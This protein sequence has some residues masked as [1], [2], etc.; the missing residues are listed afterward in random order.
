MQEPIKLLILT[1]TLGRGGA[2]KQILN[3]GYYLDPGRFRVKIVSMTALGIMGKKGLAAGLDI[4]GI[5]LKNKKKL[6]PRF[7][8]IIRRVRSWKPDILLTF[9]VHATLLG[10]LLRILGM[11]RRHIS[12]V[13]STRMGNRLNEILFRLTNAFDDVTTV[14]STN[15]AQHLIVNGTLQVG[16]I[17]VIPNGIDVVDYNNVC[18]Y[19][20]EHDAFTWIIVARIVK[21]KDYDTLLAA[22]SLLRRSGRRFVLRSVGDGVWAVRIRKRAREM[23]LEGCIE[24]LGT[25]SDI[26]ELLT[27][28]DAFVL[29]SA[30]EG[31]PNVVMEAAAASLPVVCT[32]VG[33]GSEL[34]VEG[35][36]GFLVPPGNPEALAEAMERMMRLPDDKRKAMGRYGRQHIE[37]NYSVRTVLEMWYR[38][39]VEVGRAA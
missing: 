19:R 7:L 6:V 32:D 17:V 3:L 33:G 18:E 14:N 39:L 1:S 35:R 26:P 23:S 15:T 16:R 22:V 13:R 31:M 5:D 37:R 30:W 4:E 36:S 20:H 27:D 24:F 11:A 25:R 29:S 8:R 28:A 10:R 9:M 12:S 34:V 21:A 38:L 2:D